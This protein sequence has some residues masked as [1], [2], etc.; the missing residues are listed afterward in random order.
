MLDCKSG[1]PLINELIRVFIQELRIFCDSMKLGRVAEECS[2]RIMKFFAASSSP[3]EAAVGD[4][5]VYF[6]INLY[7]FFMSWPLSAFSNI[8]FDKFF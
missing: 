6:R 3:D 1:R 8:R 7:N 5:L 4:F 2:P